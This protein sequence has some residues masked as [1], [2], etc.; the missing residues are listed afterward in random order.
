MVWVFSSNTALQPKSKQLKPNCSSWKAAKRWLS[1]QADELTGVP[2]QHHTT[3]VD[4]F[5]GKAVV[6]EDDDV[7]CSV[8]LFVNMYIQCL[9]IPKETKIF[10][11]FAQ[12]YVK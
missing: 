1:A 11:I 2:V 12:I 8:V 3:K 6:G 4:V 7:P 10:K 5:T 9:S